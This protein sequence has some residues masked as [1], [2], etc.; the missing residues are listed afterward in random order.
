MREFPL[1]H[2]LDRLIAEFEPDAPF[3]GALADGNGLDVI[4]A[5][6]GRPD[7]IE[8]RGVMCDDEI[9]GHIQTV[10][11]RNLNADAIFIFDLNNKIDDALR[12]RSKFCN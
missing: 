12:F 10:G 6:D 5:G 8:H 7:G 11:G 2:H 4:G 1:D 9:F 3:V